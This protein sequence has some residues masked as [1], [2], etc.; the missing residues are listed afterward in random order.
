MIKYN[1]YSK[2]IK[3]MVLQRFGYVISTST[4]DKIIKYMLLN[5]SFEIKDLKEIDLSMIRFTPQ[6]K[7][8][9]KYFKRFPYQDFVKPSLYFNKVEEPE[10]YKRVFRNF[11]KIKRLKKIEAYCRKEFN[12]D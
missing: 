4:I 1:K 2:E 10:V 11:K 3:K 8:L 5:L 12:S 7:S 9:H 6:K